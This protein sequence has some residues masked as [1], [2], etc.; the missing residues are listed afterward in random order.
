MSAKGR[1]LQ[2][3]FRQLKI[4]VAVWLGR[5][6]PSQDASEHQDSYIFC[7]GDSLDSVLPDGS[8]SSPSARS[9]LRVHRRSL[10]P[11]CFAGPVEC[12]IEGVI[13]MNE[14][15]TT[16]ILGLS[17]SIVA[18]PY[19]PTSIAPGKRFL[20]FLML[21]PRIFDSRNIHLRLKGKNYRATGQVR[22]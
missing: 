14:H 5:G 12:Q 9:A 20:A 11:W 19:E 18:N 1:S 22:I 7:Y 2:W 8:A 17:E 16:I 13:S 15:L 21:T 6:T 10:A 3:L 4:G